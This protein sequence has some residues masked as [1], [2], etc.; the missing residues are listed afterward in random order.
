[1]S[2]S[3]LET[4]SAI[5][6]PSCGNVLSF[7]VVSLLDDWNRVQPAWDRYV[8][9]HPRGSIFHTSEMVRAYG[10]AKGYKPLALASVAPDGR[11]AAMLVAVRV[12]T[13]PPPMGGISSR[14]IFYSEPLC[15][16]DPASIEA[17]VQLIATHDRLVRRKVLFTE[18]RP[19]YAPGPER[20]ALDRCG[21]KYLDYLN[22][23]IDV[24]QPVD[25]LW[26]DLHKSVQRA[27][28]QCERR[29]LEVREVDGSVAI[30]Q[31]YPLL[32]ASYAHSGV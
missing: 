13:L 5:P 16:D 25:R 18:V 28:R 1:M 24:T 27:V 6:A 14:S 31:L 22:L 17:L 19:L 23:L 21:Y 4:K 32:K 9:E 2:T 15:D 20:I 26:G 8:L 11:I 7:E 12:Q 30:D 3:Y 29:G 10:D